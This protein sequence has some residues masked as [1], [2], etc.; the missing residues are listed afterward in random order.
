VSTPVVADLNSKSLEDAKHQFAEVYGSSLAWNAYLKVALFLALLLTIGLVGLNLWT[1]ARY[2]DIRPLVIRVDEVGRAEAIPYDATAYQPAAAETR[3]FLTQFVVKHFSRIRVTVHRDYPESLLF[4][5]PGLPTATSGQDQESIEAFVANPVAEEI[6][7]VVKN[8]SLTQLMT[9]PYK[10]S[11]S[12]DKVF[13]TTGSRR[14][15]TRTSY[16]VQIEFVRLDRVPNNMITV[17]PLG[18]QITYL[19]P[20]QAFEVESK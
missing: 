20:D 17:N 13:L 19:H 2:A 14:E 7:V 1:H 3:Y 12:F 18:F 11:V 6:D 8:V 15:R 9:S 5:G 16:I 10:A 4:L